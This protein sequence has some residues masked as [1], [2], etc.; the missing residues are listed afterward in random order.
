MKI[1]AKEKNLL[2]LLLCI[3]LGYLYYSFVYTP[4]RE[5]IQNL[6]SERNEKKQV[7]AQMEDMLRKEGNIDL[8][9]RENREAIR[10]LADDFFG[11]IDQEEAIVVLSDFARDSQSVFNRM[12]FT[13]P[14]FE[15]ILPVEE[16]E[17]TTESNLESDNDNI[18]KMSSQID[19]EGDYNSLMS[20]LRNMKSYPKNIL[21]TNM[22]INSD[23]DGNLNGNIAMDFYSVLSVD[24]YIEPKDS[25]LSSRYIGSS[26]QLN[27][28]NSYLW[29]RTRSTGSSGQVASGRPSSLGLA[30]VGSQGSYTVNTETGQNNIHTLYGGG[31]TK[32]TVII[33]PTKTEEVVENKTPA[34]LDRYSIQMIA[35]DKETVAQNYIYI[36]DKQMVKDAYY[37]KNGLYV[38]YVGMYNSFVEALNDLESLKRY[39]KDAY[40]VKLDESQIKS[41]EDYK[42]VNN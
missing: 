20:L 11:D 29:A 25:I 17:S 39:S 12:S 16:T 23:E 8:E 27:P 7:Y 2:I 4:Q 22:N 34:S 13:E 26:S 9:L 32:D 10:I 19:F 1:S 31:A 18:R 36:L 38:V 14:A 41:Y 40:I 30:T 28:F 15:N 33:S 3:V 35:F 21:S 6:Q 5:D 37:I 24:K 42:K